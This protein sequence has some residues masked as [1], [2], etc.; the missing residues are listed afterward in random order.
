MNVLLGLLFQVFKGL[1]W[2]VLVTCIEAGVLYI[3]Q[4]IPVL[5][6]TV[7]SFLPSRKNIG[8]YEKESTPF[9]LIFFLVLLVM[10]LFIIFGYTK[11]AT[12]NFIT[13]LSAILVF[14][15]DEKNVKKILPLAEIDKL[16]FIL[17][18]LVFVTFLPFVYISFSIV[19]TLLLE[20]SELLVSTFKMPAYAALGSL[21]FIIAM[22]MY[23]SS[24]LVFYIVYKLFLKVFKLDILELFGISNLKF[25]GRWDYLDKDG[26]L[27]E[28]ASIYINSRLLFD[29]F[30][31]II[32]DD[33]EIRPSNYEL[34]KDD[35][36]IYI[37][38]N[39]KLEI[40]FDEA[41]QILVI[42]EKYKFIKYNSKEYKEKK[43]K[44][45]QNHP[46]KTDGNLYRYAQISIFDGKRKFYTNEWLTEKVVATSVDFFDESTKEE[47]NKGKIDK[48]N[49][50]SI[51]Y[52]NKEYLKVEI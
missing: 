6:S 41:N 13:L 46:K 21:R 32:S 36:S 25:N 14:F 42:D 15:L 49:S 12:W 11:V 7:F 9:G 3:L 17:I 33:D 22:F 47:I 18:K 19:N 44:V 5:L 40:S 2:I 23:L 26:N 4:K 8:K 45:S 28:G 50:D 51:K 30:S 39:K 24:V 10:I 35:D 27:V 31:Y 37:E 20:K 34:K 38:A 52:D 48:I 43:S 16:K 29:N 1:I